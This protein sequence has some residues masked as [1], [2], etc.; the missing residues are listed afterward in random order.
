MTHAS[1]TTSEPGPSVG[2][3]HAGRSALARTAVVSSYGVLGCALLW[4]RLT[5]LGKSFWFDET[6]FVE[7]YVRRGPHAIVAGPGLSHELYGLLL[8]LTSQ[9]AGESET[10]YRLWSVLP[11]IAGVA[12]VTAWLHVRVGTGSGVLFLF[13]ATVSPL[14]LDI[15]RQARGYGL[16]FL[17][18]AIVVV[19]ALEAE[20]TGRAR[21]VALACAGG[22][23]GSWTLPQFAIGF[24]A[25]AV[26]LAANPALR[27]P[28]LVGTAVS[29]AAIVA[30]FSPHVHLVKT[31]AEA[32]QGQQ[33]AT[34]WL[35]FALFGQ[36]VLPALLWIDPVLL[37]PT[38]WWIPVFV[39]AAV[40]M[41][42]SPL[43]RER[44]S[45]LILSLG[46]VATIVVLWAGD[47]YVVPRYMSFLLVPLFVLL[48]TGAANIL[49][50]IPR[51][52]APLRSLACVVVLCALALNFAR[53]APD[54][55]HLPKEAARDAADAIDAEA[56]PGVPVLT[57]VHLP[58]GLVFYLGRPVRPLEPNEVVPRV[59]RSRETVA[60]VVQPFYL[61]PVTV[62]CLSRPG[63]RH[64]RFAQYANGNETDVWI[65]PSVH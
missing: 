63:V 28:A 47:A 4:S 27:R 7:G 35:L 24:V 61:R 48:A 3:A 25:V 40:I 57:R 59:C 20:Q 13:F 38:I 29:C 60:Y 39:F 46:P 50:G 2:A 5:H 8:W 44:R 55:V 22:V 11:F 21:W 33:I 58:Q 42:S 18:M 54:V 23:V 64:F 6:V 36:I 43:L 56:P 16:A 45:A 52:R 37:I 14:L 12:I 19:A 26:V 51:R 17:A 62:P 53:I 10:A 49:A 65:V 41:S 34:A 1:G 32:P 15:T 31:A 9:F 30:W